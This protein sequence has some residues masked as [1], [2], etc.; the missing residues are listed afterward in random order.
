MPKLRYVDINHERRTAKMNERQDFDGKKECDN[1]C[2][3]LVVDDN[4]DVA[5]SLVALLQVMSVDACAVYDGLT[6]IE[7]IPSFKPQ[8][9]FLDIDM[10][11]MDGHE[12]ARRIRAIPIASAIFL[13]AFSGLPKTFRTTST[14]DVFDTYFMKPLDDRVLGNLL[15]AVLSERGAR[16]CKHCPACQGGAPERLQFN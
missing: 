4:E 15:C 10:P 9:V 3:V 8:L 16:A 7:M 12:T 1:S 2:R 6:A 11:D 14:E 13:A 5:N